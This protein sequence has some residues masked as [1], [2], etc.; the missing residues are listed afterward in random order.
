Q[1]TAK[2]VKEL[3]L[4]GNI[5]VQVKRDDSRQPKIVEVNPRI[6]GTIVHCTAAGVNLPLLAVKLAFG[7]AP[8]KDELMIK[9]GTRMVRYWEEIFY[10]G[11]GNSFVI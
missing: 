11:Q 5:G 10:D 8:R 6:Q 2:I 3:R 4:H 9:W 7:I 1:Y